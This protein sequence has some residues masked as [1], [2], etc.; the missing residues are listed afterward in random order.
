MTRIAYLEISPRQTG[1]TTRLIAFAQQKLSQGLPV[2]F[3]TFREMKKEVQAQ[4]PGAI[5]LADGEP[6]PRGEPGEGVWFYDEFDWLKY[7]ELREGAYYS[8]TAQHLR[9][10]G[11]DHPVDDLLAALIEAANYTYQRCFWPFD[12]AELLNEARQLHGPEEFRR[13]YLG[14]FLA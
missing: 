7:A 13:L 1:K 11:A 12:M 10:A 6:L 14:E 5:V 9:K 2:R 4:L 8:T 3:V